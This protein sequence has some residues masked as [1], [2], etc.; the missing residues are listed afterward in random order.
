MTFEHSFSLTLN[1][2]LTDT[3]QT[4]AP[5]K[6]SMKSHSIV[7]D[8]KQALHV[9]A[10][11]PFKGDPTLHNPEDLLLS[12]LASCHMMSYLYVC[13]QDNIQITSYKDHA[14][15]I[16]A[17]NGNGSGRITK[18]ILRPTVHIKDATQKERALELHQEANK[19]CFIANSCDFE[20]EHQ[21]A[22]FVDL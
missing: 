17:V 19:L 12:S 2:P 6:S 22:V 11:K 10:A 9:S 1:W 4:K 8:G 16:L 20:I 15:A 5:A 18:V 3:Q 21:P 14:E 13:Q 7:I